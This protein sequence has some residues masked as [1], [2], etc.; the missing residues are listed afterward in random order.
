MP[1]GEGGADAESRDAAFIMDSYNFLTPVD[2][3]HT[4][5]YWFQM[6]NLF[7]ND[8]R[9]SSLLGEGVKSAFEED[10][11]LLNAVQLSFADTRTPNID[12][13]IDAAPLR[14]RRRIAQLI[15]QQQPQGV[16]A[17]G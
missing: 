4:R 13:A 10:R 12:I 2:A 8:E 9:L 7:P 11:T 1:A 17:S 14:F 6:R 16:P 5:Y 3:G 15:Q